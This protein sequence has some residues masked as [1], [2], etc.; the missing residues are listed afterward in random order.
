MG[1]FAEYDAAGQITYGC[2]V[3]ARQGVSYAAFIARAYDEGIDPS[4]TNLLVGGTDRT[5]GTEYFKITGAGQVTL[6]SWHATTIS[7][8]HGGT[9]ATSLTGLLVGNGT[10]AFTTT[11][12]NSSNWDTAYTDRLKWDGGAT[13]LVAATG[14]TS[15]GLDIGTNVQA[16]NSNLTG[17][18]QVLD[19]TAGPSF[20]HLHLT[21]SGGILLPNAT[22]VWMNSLNAMYANSTTLVIG[23]GFAHVGM[24]IEGAYKTLSVDGS[25]FVKAA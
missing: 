10:S 14:R 21:G 15:L 23:A 12:N 4:F 16:Y 24:Y 18:N 25:G 6:G 8:D 19:T 22:A 3:E 20:N 9:G 1:A 7:V 13:G 17:I 11:T 5:T 2:M